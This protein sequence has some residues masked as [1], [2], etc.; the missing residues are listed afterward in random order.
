MSTTLPITQRRIARV[1]P[2]APRELLQAKAVDRQAVEAKEQHRW[3]RMIGPT[4]VLSAVLFGAT[5]GTGTYWL[6]GG[7]FAVG[8][9]AMI[10]G[11]IYLMISSDSNGT[12]ASVPEQP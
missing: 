3:L 4:F 10:T 1:S 9:V 11:F 7:A 6:I 5:I 2:V 12:E 8:P